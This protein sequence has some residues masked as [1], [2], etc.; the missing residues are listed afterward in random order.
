MNG[1]IA[2]KPLN[3]ISDRRIV[4]RGLSATADR[5]SVFLGIVFSTWLGVAFVQC[6]LEALGLCDA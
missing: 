4:L 1:P 6:N 2:Q 3:K 5:L